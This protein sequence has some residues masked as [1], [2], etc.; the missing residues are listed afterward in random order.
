MNLSWR[1]TRAGIVTP[2]ER[3]PWGQSL[4]MGVQ[5]ILAI[6]GATVVAPTDLHVKVY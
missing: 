6:F 3:L 2:D 5:H 1:E 4:A